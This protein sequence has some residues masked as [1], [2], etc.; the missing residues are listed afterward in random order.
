[1][2]KIGIYGYG[3]L[4]KGVEAAIKKNDD[5]KLVAVFTRRDP[6]T[7]NILTKDALVVSSDDV[8]EYNFLKIYKFDKYNLVNI[9][10]IFNN[11]NQIIK[12]L[13]TIYNNNFE[14]QNLIK[15]GFGQD[16]NINNYDL[17]INLIDNDLI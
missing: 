17:K 14:T 11:N 3:N 5:F 13:F 15:I 1:M 6:K 8:L 7:L 10:N 4:G 9:E 16:I 2:I 12:S